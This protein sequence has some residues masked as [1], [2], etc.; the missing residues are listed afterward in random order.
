MKIWKKTFGTHVAVYI[1]Q[2]DLNSTS[3]YIHNLSNASTPDIFPEKTVHVGGKGGKAAVGRLPASAC[4]S[5]APPSGRRWHW[6][7]MKVQILVYKWN[8][9][10]R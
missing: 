6:A 5:L 1:V 2:K 4:R 9:Q 3:Q 8:F 10:D 7:V